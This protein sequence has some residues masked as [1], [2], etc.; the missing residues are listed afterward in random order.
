MHEGVEPIYAVRV[1][2]HRVEERELVLTC[3]NRMEPKANINAY[4]IIVRLSAP[5]PGAVRVRVQHQLGRQLGLPN[6]ALEHAASH[7]AAIQEGAETLVFRSGALEVHVQKAPFSLKFM[8]DGQLVT[9]S[10]QNALGVM[11]VKGDRDYLMQRLSLGVGECVYGLGERFSALVRNGQ[12]LQTWNEDP[13]TETDLSYKSIPFYL[14]NRGLGVLVNHPGRVDFELATE[15]VA[16]VQF[17]VR[18]HDLDYYVFAGQT[19]K[20]AL[21]MYSAL[22]GRPTLPPLWTFGLWLSTSFLTDYDEKIV[23][24]MIDGMF[25]RGIP[26]TV[27]HFD[28]LWM[29]EHHWCDFT[30]D[31]A[32]F[33][34][35]KAMLARLKARGLKIC[36]WINPYISELSSLFA[37]GRD[38][39]YFLKRANGDV[40]Q[41]YD[42]QPGIALVDFTNP[43]ATRWYQQKLR[44]LLEQG[45]DCFKTDFGERIPADAVY[46]DGANGERMHNYYTHLY[47]EAVFSLLEEFHGPGQAAV[48]ARSATVGCQKFPV[49][50]GGDC[51]AT[52]NSMAET[53]RG[54]LSFGQSGGAFWSHD[55]GGFNSTATPALYKRWVAFGLLSSHSRLHGSHSYRVPWL[56]DEE[57]VEVLRAF[58]ELKHSLMPYLWR[59]A[60]QATETGAP[61]LRAMVLEFPSDP[62]THYLDRQF[63][64]GD[65]LLVAPVFNET[66]D[67]EYYLP[68]GTWT[69]YSSGERVQ[70]G[71]WRREQGVPFKRIPLFVRPNTLLARGTRRDT[72]AY[73]FL[74]ELE[75]ELFEV[76]DGARL[77]T[78]VNAQAG[79]QYATFRCVRA[80][81]KLTL[82]ATGASGA[83]PRVIVRGVGEYPWPNVE[84]VLTI[85]LP[86]SSPAR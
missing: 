40:Y 53:L 21:D 39:G 20:D 6:F 29:R 73:D 18:D 23:G 47:N 85:E 24:G 10:R 4:A 81:S 62:A 58:T 63:M 2:E 1:H 67:V 86:A 68:A 64:L 51:D 27:F 72:P 65:A 5:L 83:G 7:K 3:L 45:V 70:G 15:R 75:L 35:P 13:G 44:A 43:E 76:A 48:F 11:N 54:G 55:I 78:R 82:S 12:S 49:H 36:V 46:F 33:P 77:E 80:G 17:S 60:H 37:E 26:L 42:W 14:T 79:T 71:T 19:P 57:S 30:W 50:W 74:R 59:A 8:R 69:D 61:M 34:D 31:P 16:A 66:G 38:A 84:Q 25:E 56:F 9:E 22:S 28:C 32:K 52:F 41:R